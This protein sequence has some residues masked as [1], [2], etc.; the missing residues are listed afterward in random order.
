MR[1]LYLLTLLT[2]FSA[3]CQQVPDSIAGHR[4]MEVRIS[5]LHL[6]DSLMNAPASIAILSSADLLRN[7][8][9]DIAPAMNTVSGVLMQSGNYNTNRISIRGIGART[10]YGTNKIR[11][12][13][14]NIPLTSGD[15]ET[16]I[17]DIDIEN[18]QQIEIIKG[19]LSSLYGA[20]L[21]GAILLTPKLSGRSSASIGSTH[22]SFGLVKNNISLHYDD[23]KGSINVSYHKL[24][25]DGWRENSAYDREGV[26]V[27]GELFRK[28]HSKLTY[29]GN[30]TYMKA[31]IPSSIDLQTFT[32]R[33]QSAAFTWRASKGFE[34]Y[35]AYL[36]GLSYEFKMGNISNATSVFINARDSN[37]P[38]PFDILNQ[39][40]T[41]YGARTQFAVDLESKIF[42]RFI[43]G[44]EYFADDFDA[45]TYENLYEDNNGNGS[46][47]GVQIGGTAQHRKFYNA[48]SQLRFELARK[49]ELQAGL[50]LN[51]TAFRLE[52]VFPATS[53]YEER[54]QYDAI[55]APQVSLLY[56]PTDLRTYYLS[57]SRGFSLPGIEETLTAEGTINSN[58]RPETGY[59]FEAGG[60]VF[61]LNRKL[62]LEAALFRMLITDL[63]VAQRVGDDQYIGVNAGETLHQGIEFSGKYDW[64]LGSITI[65]PQV[66]ISIGRYEFEDFKHNDQDYSGN[67]LTGVPD[68]T[69]NAGISIDATC[70]LYFTS[71]YQYVGAI[72]LNDS[73]ANFNDAYRIFNIKSGYRREI[74]RNIYF[75]VAAGVNNVFDEHYASMVLPNATG[76]GTAQP[77]FYYP[78]LPV[79]YYGQ[80]ALRYQL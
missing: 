64:N 54:Y 13:Y 51:S 27:V 60:K 33:P 22:G 45:Q 10:P 7:N 29:F 37:E 9:A 50:N 65:T 25:S 5:A 56:K 63:L 16:T 69:L 1:N 47:Q 38:R 61:L 67:E 34:Q 15:S 71:D 14:G 3:A 12:F 36:G 79:N 44:A 48:F 70:G 74:L 40:T 35:D 26:T 80:L 19:P 32:D 39:N 52:N 21:G 57:A 58:I 4:L 8:A 20:G 53:A 41:A 78:G 73:N 18:I 43:V 31:F 28:T 49:V 72:P 11:A 24:K 23:S 62:Y 66:A 42:R 46:L 2:C 30:Y 55:W 17:D 77:R 76:F 6:N 68:T 59:N 75:S